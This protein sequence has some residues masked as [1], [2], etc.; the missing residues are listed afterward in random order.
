MFLRT[1]NDFR[2][3]SENKFFFI[4]EVKSLYT[5]ISNDEGLRA[6]KDFFDRRT[7]DSRYF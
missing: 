7:V 5:V 4:M 3:H 6:L 2:F 1:L